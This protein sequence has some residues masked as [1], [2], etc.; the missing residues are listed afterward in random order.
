MKL[1]D[2]Y[3]ECLG[4]PDSFYR[5]KRV[6]W[7]GSESYVAPAVC[8]LQGLARLGFEV[9]TIGKPNINS[10]FCN[11]VVDDPSG[12]S[13]DLVLSS[14]HWGTRWGHYRR[15]GLGGYLKVLIDG[16]D[17]FSLNHTWRDK[18]YFW[19]DRYG[20]EESG[21]VKDAEVSDYRWM[22]A[23]DDYK[24]DVVFT[25]QKSPRDQGTFY[26]PSGIHDQYAEM[27]RP[28][29]A[30]GD[31]P[32]DFAHIPGPG[33][34]RRAMKDLL[35]INALPGAVH[36]EEIRGEP[37]YPKEIEDLARRDEGNI[38][39]YHRWACW[40]GFWDVLNRSKVLIHPGIDSLPF[41]DCKRPYEGMAAGCLV[42]M[43]EP[44]TDVSDYPPTEVCPEAVFR[45]HGELMDK[46]RFW[47][48]HPDR[49][50][51]LRGASAERGTR[52]FAP[53]AVA[54]YFLCRTKKAL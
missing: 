36:N 52:F 28:D 22:E 6:L 40:V 50:D 15:Y 7:I 23:L 17:T 3:Q 30:T 26:I 10:W 39:S 13:L 43:R 8:V 12:L 53:E 18:Y 24:P 31:R 51:E 4:E 9:C 20:I 49:L 2:V 14:L 41:W 42:A 44:C 48:A 54:R 1:D 45:N 46:A 38:H 16:D 29:I 35:S 19:R 37:V 47:H 32:V 25:M 21:S 33:A 5:H 34:W 27:G 11:R